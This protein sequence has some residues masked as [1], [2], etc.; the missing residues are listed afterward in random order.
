MDIVLPFASLCLLLAVGKVL[1]VKVRLFQRLYLPASVIAGLL[2]L[3][4]VQSVSWLSAGSSPDIAASQSGLFA[5]H[6]GPFVQSATAGWNYLPGFLINI[7]F[8]AL[9][10]GLTVPPIKSIWQKAGP[11]LAYGQIVAWGQYATALAVSLAVLAPLLGVHA[12]MGTIVPVGFEGGHGTAGGLAQTFEFFDWPEGT[13]YALAAA[14]AGMLFAIII[15]MILVNW[16]ARRGYAQKLK[17]IEDMPESSIIG[18]FPVEERPSAGRQ[19]V[20]AASVDSLALHLAIIG[21]AIFVGYVFKQV[22][23][24]GETVIRGLGEDGQAFF[25]GFPLFPLCMIGG[26]IV[27]ILLD[28]FTKVN[29][30]DHQLMQRLSGASMDFLVVAA[31]SII[32]LDVVMSG[33]VPFAILIIVGVAWN[34]FCVTWLA[35]RLLPQDSWFERAI[36]EMGQSMGVTATGLLLLRVVDPEAETDATS[37]FGYKQIL[38]E[39]FMGGGLWTSAAIPLAIKVGA[40]PVFLISA[41][42][43]AA[44]LTVWALLFRK[45]QGSEKGP[46]SP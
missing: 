5:S 25:S 14:T 13:D 2:G 26:L 33:I 39:P 8:A 7:V 4:L 3:L 30:I 19:T 15:G 18:V 6:I 31:I 44:W 34:G 11:Q 32:R 38:H 23:V 41:G 45:T 21:V 24:G 20:S 43:M 37:A 16:A 1:R 27:Q 22:L 28:R 46:I 10:L 9:F 40:L 29:P 42:V 12:Y 35:R 36:A 17:R